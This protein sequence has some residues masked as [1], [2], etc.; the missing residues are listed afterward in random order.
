MNSIEKYSSVQKWLTL[1]ASTSTTR[2]GYLSKFRY[3][4]KIAKLNPDELIE[5]WKSVKYDPIAKQKFIDEVGETVQDFY[6]YVLNRKTLAELTKRNTMMV[7]K[8]FFKFYK[9]PLEVDDPVM[10]AR[11]TFHNRSITKEEI[12]KILDISAPREKAF[13]LMMVETGFRPDTLV[14]LQYK[15]IKAE[16]E[17]GKI[18]MKIDLPAQLLKDR[19]GDRF[20]FLGEDGYNAL[21]TYLNTL[22]KLEDTDYIFQPEKKTVKKEP[23][24]PTTFSNYFRKMALKMGIVEKKIKGKPLPI[25]LYCL[26]KYFRNNCRLDPSIR[27]FFMGH[28]LGTDEHYIAR[29]VE[30]YRQMYAKNYETLRIYEKPSL[31]QIIPPEEFKKMVMEY[32]KTSE[33]QE[34]LKEAIM[35][36]IVPSQ[37]TKELF[38]KLFGRG[39]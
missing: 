9:I 34:L 5:R 22:G 13:F 31:P 30:L 7:V 3:F 24:P 2:N 38:M 14:K 17:Q 1:R 39:T 21:K 16:Y 11:V 26:R 25:R 32:L 28:S 33:G 27:E 8:S 10:K 36:T 19:V 23:L 6:V 12:R 29:D 37:I 35:N 18:P 15:H 20:T 4:L